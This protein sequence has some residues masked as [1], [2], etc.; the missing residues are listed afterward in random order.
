[1]LSPEVIQE[2]RQRNSFCFPLIVA[3]EKFSELCKIGQIEFKNVGIETPQQ[4]YEPRH[5][6]SCHSAWSLTGAQ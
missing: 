2:P 6:I 4:G 5:F 3:D 1:M